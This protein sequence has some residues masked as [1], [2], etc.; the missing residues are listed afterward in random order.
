MSTWTTIT[1]NISSFTNR[2][3]SGILSFL[4]VEDNSY[5]LQEDSSKIVLEYP[6]EWTNLTKSI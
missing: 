6:I 2:V 4:K 5:L 3:K 1:K